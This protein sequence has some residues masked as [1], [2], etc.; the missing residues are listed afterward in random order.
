MRTFLN[1]RNLEECDR[2][3][4]LEAKSEQ[5]TLSDKEKLVHFNFVPYYVPTMPDA[6]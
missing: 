6:I 1:G 2:S 5:S 3:R 4:L